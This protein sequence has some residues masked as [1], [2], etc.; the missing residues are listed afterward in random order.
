[1]LGNTWN[2]AWGWSESNSGDMTH[3]VGKKM[4]NAWGLYDMHGNVWE[5]VWDLYDEYTGSYRVFR[6][7]S[8]DYVALL[9]R[10][11]FRGFLQPVLQVL[12]SWLPCGARVPL[13]L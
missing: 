9:V 11:A 12:Q 7:G 2:D 3:E 10:S 5:W 6:G 8:W 13:S 1:N 4:P